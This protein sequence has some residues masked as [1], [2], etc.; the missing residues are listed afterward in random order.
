MATL[1]LNGV[2]IHYEDTGSGSEA[3]VFAHG[4]LFSGLMFQ[5]QIEALRPRY[6]CV[7]FDFRGQGQSEVT[8]SGYD[9]D[10][11]TEDAATLIRH[12]RLAPCHFVGLSMGGF[13][14]MRLGF[15]YP[16]LLKSLTLLETSADPEPRANVPKYRFLALVARW[17]GLGV[18]AGRV[19]PIV[20]GTKFLNDPDRV[21]LLA[22]WR[23]RV[24]RNDRRGI[25]RAVHGVIERQGVAEE[26]RRIRVPTLV[27]V[28]DQDVATTPDKAQRIHERI[29][30]SRLVTVSG[31]G[32]S[33]SIEEPGLVNSAL[34]RFLTSLA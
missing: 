26:I 7:T 22:E 3:V 14:G 33:A 30:N 10:S 34:L 17:C 11:L 13:V 12:L 24:I 5:A 29:P 31:A 32:H 1:S 9:M 15:R 20:F 25:L 18:V 28:G 21:A 23:D 19:L 8:E 16:E 6:R 27:M 4:L 2:R